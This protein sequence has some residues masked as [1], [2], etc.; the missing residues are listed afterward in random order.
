MSK[1]KPS[2]R[3]IML[4]KKSVEL[5]KQ[6]AR[7]LKRSTPLTHT[8]AIELVVQKHGFRNWNHFI[9]LRKRLATPVLV[10]LGL[11]F[12]ESPSAPCPLAKPAPLYCK[13]FIVDVGER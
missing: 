5:L 13:N 6:E 8:Q 1:S 4:G 3:L 7:K 2:F 10:P 9:E 12:R 11:C